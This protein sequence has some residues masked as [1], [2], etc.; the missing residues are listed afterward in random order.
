MPNFLSVANFNKIPMKNMVPE[1]SS[2]APADP[3][4]GQI[5]YDTATKKLKCYENGV[6]MVLSA[7]TNTTYTAGTTAEVTAGTDVVNKIWSPLVF[8]ASVLALLNKAAVGLGNV[9]NTSDVSKPVST[10]QATAIGLKADLASPT[11]TGDPKAPTPTAGDNDT[12]VATTA[13]VQT[14]ILGKANSAS[15]TFTGTVTVPT[16]ATGTAAAN[17]DY[18]DGVAQGLS[19]KGSVVA[20]TTGPVTIASAGLAIIDGVQLVAGNRVLVKNQPGGQEQQNGIYIAAA[21]AW[22]RA[23]DMNVWAEVPGAFTFVEKGTTQQDTGWVCVSNTFDSG[24]AP[25]IGTDP[26]VWTQ[27]SSAGI[28]TAG[29]GLTKTGNVF[30]VTPGGITATELAT[31]AVDLSSNDVTGVLPLVKGGT[32]GATAPAA[33]FALGAASSDEGVLGALTAGTWANIPVGENGKWDNTYVFQQPALVFY[34]STTFETIIL[35]TR[36]DSSTNKMQVRSDVAVVAGPISYSV[37]GTSAQGFVA[38]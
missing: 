22:T 36:I 23:S 14:A 38:S 32:G 8:K 30:S 2:T 37:V 15:P 6:W 24:A 9:D 16:P 4:E 20:A 18:V 26:I 27:F 21:G 34:D 13:F 7:D 5:Y 3:T 19:S 29:T 11:F 25:V 35:D 28:A 17:K 31:G 1:S 33:R 10:A 12:S